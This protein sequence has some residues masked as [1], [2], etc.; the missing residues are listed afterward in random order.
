MIGLRFCFSRHI[1]VGW[2]MV[3]LL[4]LLLSSYAHAQ[5]TSSGR[6]PITTGPPRGGDSSQGGSN[7]NEI[8]PDTFPIFYHF[9]AEPWRELSFTDSLLDSRFHQHDPVRQRLFDFQH[10]GL[11]GSPVKPIVYEPLLRAGFDW[12]IHSY[13]PYLLTAAAVPVYRLQ[14]AYTNLGF[15]QTG[16]QENNYFTAQF[17]RNFAQ[18][19]NFSLDYQRLNQLGTQTL[20][21]NQGGRNTSLGLNFWIKGKT[22]R[23][24]GYFTIVH[25][26]LQQKDNGG[27]TEEPVAQGAFSSLGLAG[28]NLTQAQV[29]IRQ[30]EVM[31]TQYFQL[32]KPLIAPEPPPQPPRLPRDTTARRSLPD[33]LGIV[34][35]SLAIAPDS[36]R[37]AVLAPTGIANPPA[38]NS[39]QVFQLAHSIGL[40]ESRFLYFDELPVA[41]T[42]ARFYGPY[43]TDER[44]LRQFVQWTRLE[45]SFRLI[46]FRS[47]TASNGLQVN[48]T[49]LELGLTHA[50]H[51]IKE[52]PGDSSVNNL[53]LRGRLEIQP[54]TRF[55]LRAAALLD[56]LDNAGDYQARAE[57]NVGLGEV[58]ALRIGFIN[59]LYSPTLVQQR[60]FVTQ[61]A[62]WQNNFKKTLETNLSAAIRLPALNLEIGGNYNLR[63]NLIY[64]DTTGIPQQVGTPVSIGQLTLQHTFRIGKIFGESLLAFQV[65]GDETV[66]RL[67]QLFGKHGVYFRGRLFKVLETRLG[68]DLR[69][70]SAYYADTYRA[71]SGQYIRQDRQL[72][73][74]YPA[75]DVYLSVRI[76]KMRA[77]F[78]WENISSLFRDDLFYQT[79]FYPQPPASGFRLGLKWR[80]IE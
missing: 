15:N 23:Y 50:I 49:L 27:I 60:L 48:P 35:D 52:E 57:L 53:L 32:S 44:G 40:R 80:L 18:G 43:L 58:A 41:D 61:E 66:V 8:E 28:V 9:S 20:F 5:R 78:K 42:S 45:N 59:Q 67:P 19:L 6:P 30:N 26:K 21:P 70:Q 13:N 62:V 55:Q 64:F 22:Q 46:T 17:S 47:R 65:S 11:P 75:T 36:L 29:R 25:N 54:S 38:T 24:Q 73:P 10:L 77:F 63:N 4:L 69:Y 3:G 71:I 39:R 16:E 51:W 2:F 79:A 34:P 74:W 72:V 56:V 68:V 12:G 31:Y 7:Q 33:S 1:L 37:G 76:T 14:R